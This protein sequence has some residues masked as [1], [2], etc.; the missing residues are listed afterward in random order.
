MKMDHHEIGAGAV[1]LADRLPH[2]L[3][4]AVAGILTQHG[5]MERSA[6]RQ[7][8]LQSLPTPD[9]RDATAAFLDL[10][11]GR[12]DSVSAE[13][14]AIA[15]VTAAAS[16][17][18]HRQEKSVEI[19]WTGPEPAD[20]RF[21]RTEQAILEVIHA[22]HSRLTVVS[23]AV[24]R[25]PRIR[26]ALVAAVN[27]GVNIRLILET[28]NRIEGQGEYDC[29]MALGKN[30]ASACSV[31]YWPQEN[32]AKDDNGKIGILHVKC[33]VADGQ[34][35]FLSSANLTEYAFT[36]NM[37]LGTLITGGKLPGR[38]EEHFNRLVITSVLA[39]L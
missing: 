7:A 28:P 2:S 1:R 22:A 14:V 19:V 34:W 3:M 39:V 26:E 35:L 13:E 24:Y 4:V 16:N 38:I 33:L 27:R 36:I 6:S 18:A 8:I 32:R 12:A 21:R 23:Y 25:I 17:L 9:F 15:L 10:W 11:H 30:V 37:E 31:Y 29:L 20:T 5:G